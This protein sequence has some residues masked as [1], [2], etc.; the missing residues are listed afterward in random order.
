MAL[1]F[2]GGHSRLW[3][4]K[5]RR[6]SAPL[7]H[8]GEPGTASQIEI[9][10]AQGIRSGP[11]SSCTTEG[12]LQRTWPDRSAQTVRHRP[13]ASLEARTQSNTGEGAAH[14]SSFHRC[15]RAA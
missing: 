7:E 1:A 9:V 14:Y 5:Q 11:E 3:R 4:G 12:T 13:C 8:I 10:E 6:P 15:T 2:S